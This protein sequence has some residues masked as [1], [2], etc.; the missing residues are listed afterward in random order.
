[1]K[2][3]YWDLQAQYAECKQEIDKGIAGIIQDSEYIGG[4]IQSDFEANLIRY[5]GAQD[6][7]TVSSGTSALVLAY[8][9]LE[10]QPGDEVITPSLTFG[11]GV[12]SIVQAGGT[13]VFVDID[14]YFHIDVDK[15]EDAIT[16]K[17]KV[18]SYV[19][20][21]GQT[22]NI[23]KLKKLSD[24]HNLCLVEDGAHA[25][26]SS[27]KNK[28]VGTLADITTFSFNIQKNLAG[29]GDGGAV[30]SMYDVCENIR[31][32]R[33]HGRTGIRGEFDEVGYNARLS[34]INSVVCL[35]KLKKLDEWIDSKRE[36]CKV[37]DEELANIVQIPLQRPD[38]Y[39]TFY[40][41]VIQCPD[42]TRDAL[43][44]F[45]Q[46][47]GI[48]TRISW[49][50]GV[51]MTQAYGVYCLDSLP[52]TENVTKNI[53]SLPCYHTLRDQDHV[54]QKVKEFYG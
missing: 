24:K 22:P 18:I 27:W 45:L 35:A 50:M 53:L 20:L 36:I 48:Q 2:V 21:Y 29:F 13:P 10:L 9:T 42:N 6:V 37:Y 15:I 23:N 1:M 30:S 5:T 31:S 8:H 44:K 51:H 16:E 26:G 54:I 38:S 17:T 32:L 25:F 33:V 46:D 7:A 11:A 28:K 49:P 43:E 52:K 3:P 12:E 19:S 4:K 39:H 14:E 34:N 47:N 40:A 41:Y